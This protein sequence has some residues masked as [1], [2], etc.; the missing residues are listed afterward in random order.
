MLSPSGSRMEAEMIRLALLAAALPSLALAE[1][2]RVELSDGIIEHAVRESERKL[3]RVGFERDQLE[4]R[5]SFLRALRALPP[6]D[7]ADA[8]R[9]FREAQRETERK[10]KDTL[11]RKSDR[12]VTV[13]D[14]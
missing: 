8:W 12:F 11:E 1:P 14:A 6:A 9:R 4:E 3:E 5:R 13:G 7:R 10:F 2:A